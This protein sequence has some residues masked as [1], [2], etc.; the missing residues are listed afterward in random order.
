MSQLRQMR[1][2]IACTINITYFFLAFLP[3]ESHFRKL[4]SFNMS[5]PITKHHLI[6]AKPLIGVHHPNTP[7]LGSFL[8][9]LSYKILLFFGLLSFSFSFSFF[10]GVVM[11]GGRGV[12]ECKE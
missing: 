10:F 7:Q 3:K 1:Q 2:K 6:L 9:K 4:I 8:I 5:E 12:L 11:V